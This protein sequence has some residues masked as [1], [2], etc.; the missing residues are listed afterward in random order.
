[1][2]LVM[3]ICDVLY[4]LDFGRLIASGTPAE[5]RESPVVRAA[6]LG[7]SSVQIAPVRPAGSPSSPSEVGS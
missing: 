1:M 4:V 3:D 5:M 6:Y 7:D 2:T